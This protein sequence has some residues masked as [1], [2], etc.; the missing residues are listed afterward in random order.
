MRAVEHLLRA[1]ARRRGA[2]F[3]VPRLP[4]VRHAAR[5]RGAS[6]P[7]RARASSTAAAARAP[8]SSCSADSA[9][10][11]GSTCRRSACG[12][13]AR[14]AGRRVARATVTA[15]P[16]PSGAFDLVTS[17]DVL[18]SLE[19]RDERAAVARTV[20][21]AQAGRL[22]RR[23]RRGDADA[24]RRS[25][26][27]QPRTAALHAVVAPAAAR[28]GRLHDRPPDL[29]ERD[30]VPAARDG[31]RRFTGGVACRPRPRR[32]RRSPCRRRRSTARLSA[33]LGARKPLAAGHRQPVRQ[34]AAVSG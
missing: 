5:S 9:A 25:L 14:P 13:P 7:D 34:L 29:H 17:F 31:A 32:S 4:R 15:A 24:D 18:Y 20:P 19:E 11:T 3:L 28:A 8:T 16:F 27:A 2:A 10:P 12:S 26:G 22:R 30:A 33:L 21:R 23:Q 6:R 1:T